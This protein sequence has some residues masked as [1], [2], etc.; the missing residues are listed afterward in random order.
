MKRVCV[1]VANKNKRIFRWAGRGADAG[2]DEMDT[3][4]NRRRSS[5]R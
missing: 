1:D 5:H 3:G 2:R 4:Q